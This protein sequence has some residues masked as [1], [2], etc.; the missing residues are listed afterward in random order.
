MLLSEL[1]N[2]CVNNEKLENIGIIA[3]FENNKKNIYD[4]FSKLAV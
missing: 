2:F 4:N 1:T 3:W